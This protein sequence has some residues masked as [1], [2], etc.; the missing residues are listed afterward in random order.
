MPNV[1][2]AGLIAVAIVCVSGCVTSRPYSPPPLRIGDPA[3]FK[4]ERD[5]AIRD[6]GS[7]EAAAAAAEVRGSECDADGPIVE[8]VAPDLSMPVRSGFPIDVRWRG[9]TTEVHVVPE[10]TQI[11][12]KVVWWHDITQTV[13]NY[14]RDQPNA[15]LDENGLKVPAAQLPGLG[16][17]A[18]RVIVFDSKSKCTAKEI[19]LT[20]IQ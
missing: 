12:Y 2:D 1:I 18:L 11:A 5:V 16:Q 13:R 6:F 17:Q 8:V 3:Q 4:G 10:K 20:M 7:V 15:V 14:L 19:T 9:R